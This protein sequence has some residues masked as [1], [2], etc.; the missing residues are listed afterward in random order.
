MEIWL[1]SC[2][3]MDSSSQWPDRCLMKQDQNTQIINVIKETK[4]FTRYKWAVCEIMVILLKN[5]LSRTINLWYGVFFCQFFLSYN[6]SS[7]GH[8]VFCVFNYEVTFRKMF[9]FLLKVRWERG[10]HSPV[11][12]HWK[13]KLADRHMPIHSG[14]GYFLTMIYLQTVWNDLFIFV[15]IMPEIGLLYIP[16]LA[17]V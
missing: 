6:A 17:W 5:Y 15:L 8:T 12:K 11:Q 7:V 9:S 16:T 3:H 14:M 4:H 10:Y 1:L 13:Q 2:V